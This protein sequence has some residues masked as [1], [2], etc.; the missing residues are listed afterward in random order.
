MFFFLPANFTCIITEGNAPN[1]HKK[2]SGRNGETAGL[3]CAL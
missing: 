3:C 2:M 1:P